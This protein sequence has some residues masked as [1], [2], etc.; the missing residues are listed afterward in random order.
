MIMIMRM[1]MRLNTVMI[2]GLFRQSAPVTVTVFPDEIHKPQ[3]LSRAPWTRPHLR[4][5]ATWG[6]ASTHSLS[7][8]KNKTK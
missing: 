8:K 5:I 2:T 4:L 6:S 1:R 7:H 3:I